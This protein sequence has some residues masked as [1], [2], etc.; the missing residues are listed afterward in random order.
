LFSV[1][2]SVGVALAMAGAVRV[3]L[4]ATQILVV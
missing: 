2:L 3:L 1:S 4:E